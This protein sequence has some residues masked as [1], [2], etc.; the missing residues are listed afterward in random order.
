MIRGLLAVAAI[1]PIVAE[2]PVAA[3]LP[4]HVGGRVVTEDDGSLSFGWP[5]TY[6]EGRFHGT[7]IRVRADAPTDFLGL[8]IDGRA[9]TTLRKPGSADVTIDGLANNDHVVR[10]EKRT[11]SQTGGTRFFGFYPAQNSVVLPPPPVRRRQIEFIGDSYT[12][13]YGNTSVTTACDNNEVHDRTDTQQAF[14]PLVA[15]YFQADYRIN[16]YS[17]FGI[18]RNYNGSSPDSSMPALYDRLKPDDVIHRDGPRGDWQPQIIVINLG[19][20]D[21]STPVHAGE[22]WPDRP[23]LAAAYRERYVGFA[24][25]IAARQPQARMILMASPMFLD[26]VEQVAAM[27]KNR[28]IPN[29][30]VLSFSELALSACDFH[31]SLDDER[32]L[33]VSLQ[34]AIARLAIWPGLKHMPFGGETSPD[35]KLLTKMP[36]MWWFQY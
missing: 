1:A 29:V 8:L 13:G 24:R 15:R 26:E 30:T 9:V 3:P 34:Q 19:T 22:R 21:F 7:A 28:G 20:N 25:Q 23:T 10:L 6:I 31:P 4:V 33:A 18:V 27:V 16:A 2:P 5:G 11:E 36:R 17:G 35:Q 12:V 32:Q 14:G